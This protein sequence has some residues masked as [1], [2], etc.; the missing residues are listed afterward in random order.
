[1]Y[2]L[3]LSHDIV[4]YQLC[5]FTHMGNLRS[6]VFPFARK[7]MRIDPVLAAEGML[8]FFWACSGVCGFRICLV[9]MRMKALLKV[10]SFRSFA[11]R[12][13]FDFSR[14]YFVGVVMYCPRG[15]M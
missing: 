6:C 5:T 11:F 7:V 9:E 2:C 13:C 1:M 14:V 3:I 15:L 4:L 8:G 12:A 10:Q